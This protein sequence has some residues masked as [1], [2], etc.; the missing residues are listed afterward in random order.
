MANPRTGSRLEAGHIGT[1]GSDGSLQQRTE[2]FTGA[3]AVGETMES[4]AVLTVPG[5]CQIHE[6][7]VSNATALKANAS[8]RYRDCPTGAA[9]TAPIV[10]ATIQGASIGEQKIGHKADA[11]HMHETTV[12][13]EFF[14]VG[15]GTATGAAE[16]GVNQRLVVSIVFSNL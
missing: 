16:S 9:K 1:M 7:T 4:P 8:L 15:G 3:I 12:P 6:I 2:V 11:V 13:R 10:Y 5:E 14:L